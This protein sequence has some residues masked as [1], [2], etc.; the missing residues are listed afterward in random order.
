MARGI[1][2]FM[3]DRCAVSQIECE[4]ETIG[5]NKLLVCWRCRNQMKMAGQLKIKKAPSGPLSK[6]LGLR[7]MPG[8]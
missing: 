6:V 1:S 4:V 5:E 7:L 2:K 3:C 8:R